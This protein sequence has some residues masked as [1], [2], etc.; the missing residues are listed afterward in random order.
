MA[1]LFI[2]NATTTDGQQIEILIRNGMIADLSKSIGPVSDDVPLLDAGGWLTTSA[3]IDSH[4][5]LDTT[6]SYGLPR[7]NQSGTLLEGIQ[8]WGEL[9][10]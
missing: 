5:H 3:F 4:F 1:D 9:K 6:L 10:P 7:T 8:L 2:T